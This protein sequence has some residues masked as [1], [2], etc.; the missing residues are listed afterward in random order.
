MALDGRLLQHPTR[1]EH[2][3]PPLGL[4]FALS[5]VAPVG[6][7]VVVTSLPA[8]GDAFLAGNHEVFLVMSL[9]M[10]V[11]GAMQL[12]L[13][14]LSDRF[15]RRPV[16]LVGLAL[17]TSASL[18]CALAKSLD[19]LIVARC[20]QALGGCAALAIP[21][22]IVRDCHTGV[23]GAR[24]MTVL[25][26]VQ[27]IVPAVAP[28]L[29]GLL[30]AAAGWTAVFWF[31]AGY[32]L[33][34]LAWAALSLPETRQPMTPGT[35]PSTL[36]ATVGLLRRPAYL[37]YVLNGAL[38]TVPYVLYLTVV[39]MMFVRSLDLPPQ[40]FGTYNLL[41]VP[42]ILLGSFAASLLARRFA[43]HILIRSA[44]L[45]A[46]ASLGLGLALAGEL[47]VWRMLLPLLLYITAHAVL[48]PSAMSAA[49]A[50]SPTIAGAAAGGIGS[51]QTGLGALAIVAAGW[52]PAATAVPFLAMSCAAGIAGLLALLMA[53]GGAAGTTRVR[54]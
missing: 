31:C 17:F 37:A 21:R 19:A 42:C 24:A 28:L 30:V 46:L 13:G 10:L 40:A 50:G 5:A 43:V 38:M 22:A 3:P 20:V 45:L 6:F 35:A 27:S 16:L 14:P 51:V 48:F 49:I 52:L 25:A 34:T 41:L 2:S 23:E 29:G 44:S 53:S 4:L 15:G 7:S 8:V 12:V 33:A 39:P 18:G 26:M 9:F 32:G 47:S 54:A 1:M 36:Q 11:F